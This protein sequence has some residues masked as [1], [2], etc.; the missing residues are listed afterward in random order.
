MIAQIEQSGKSFFFARPEITDDSMSDVVYKISSL[1]RDV[2]E[3]TR[4]IE[5]LAV[6]D[7]QDGAQVLH[8]LPVRRNSLSIPRLVIPPV[9]AAPSAL[10]PRAP[11]TALAPATASLAGSAAVQRQESRGRRK[12]SLQE[13]GRYKESREAE[14]V[15]GRSMFTEASVFSGSETFSVD[16]TPRSKRRLSRTKTESVMVKA[17]ASTRVAPAVPERRGEWRQAAVKKKVSN[18][19]EPLMKKPRSEDEESSSWSVLFEDSESENASK[20]TEAKTESES[21][22]WF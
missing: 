18:K 15:E 4:R 2:Q 8:D 22:G 21:S 9:V 11:A 10:P 12:S 13:M 14:V 16:V 20:Y 3:N 19:K 17:Q 5:A 6:F 1:M 7:P